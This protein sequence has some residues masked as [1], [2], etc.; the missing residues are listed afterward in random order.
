ME[1]A[2]NTQ[3]LNITLDAFQAFDTNIPQNLIADGP[4]VNAE[5]TTIEG[6]SGFTVTA[7]AYIPSGEFNPVVIGPEVV[8]SVA[9]MS[10]V[11]YLNYYGVAVVK[12]ENREGGIQENLSRDFRIE[13]NMKNTSELYDLYYIKFSYVLPEGTTPVDMIYV[14]EQNDDPETDR[15]T[16]TTPVKVP[17]PTL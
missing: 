16:I 2:V 8:N 9:L 12:T 4:L 6:K 15:G 3:Q 1:N 14:R 5:A 13:F 11:L 10:N 7:L 17:P